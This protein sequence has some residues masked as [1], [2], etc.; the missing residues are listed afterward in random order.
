MRASK[1]LRG[2]LQAQGRHRLSRVLQRDA[3]LEPRDDLRVVPGE[4]PAHPRRER[5]GHPLAELVATGRV[6]HIGLSEAGAATIRRAHVVHPVT[7]LQT[8]YSLWTRGLE[9]ELLPLLRQLGSDSLR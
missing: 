1:V 7:A 6:R 2:H 3:G 5:R 9:A 4:V 8:E